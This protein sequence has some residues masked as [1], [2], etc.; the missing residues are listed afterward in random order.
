MGECAVKQIEI[1]ADSLLF[2]LAF[3]CRK[4][5][6]L[7]EW[8]RYFESLI[9]CLS[10][11]SVFFFFC[12]QTRNPLRQRLVKKVRT[13]FDSVVQLCLQFL[14]SP[15]FFY[16]F[17]LCFFIFLCVFFHLVF[18]TSEISGKGYSNDFTEPTLYS[19]L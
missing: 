16:F 7:S 4:L 5:G 8:E 3:P 9:V 15:F 2:G 12:R 13:K 1:S 11:N 14:N 17:L 10:P 19:I 6:C 18:A